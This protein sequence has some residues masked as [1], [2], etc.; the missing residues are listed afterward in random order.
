LP[1]A[2]GG[3]DIAVTTTLDHAA[4]AGAAEASPDVVGDAVGRAAAAFP[5]WRAT[6]P[7]ERAACLRR[8]AAAVRAAAD[9]L[10]DS[11]CATT[12]RLLREA[13]GSALVAADILDEAAVTGLAGGR[14][15][16]GAPGAVDWV[17]PEPRGVVAVITPWNDPL[18]AAAGLLAAALVTGNT[19][20]HKPSERSLAPGLALGHAVAGCL[21]DGVLE[22]VAG[23]AEVGRW[24]VDDARVAVVAHVG[25]SA[26]G[27]AIREACGRRGAK[28]ITE[29]G[30]KDPLVVDAGVDPRWAA[31]QIAVGAFTNAGQLCTSVER[32][33]LHRDVAAEVLAE[34]VRAAEALRGGDPR[35]ETTTLGP[36]VD[37]A[38]LAV[39]EEHVA[40]AVRR[41]ARVITGGRRLDLPGAWYAPTV[42]DR[43]T[44]DMLVMTEET[45]GPVA[46]VTVVDS[47]GEGLELAGLGRYGLA[48]TVLTPDQGHA[49]AAVDA[50]DVGTVKVN[51]VFGGAPGGSADPRRDSG[52]GRGYGPDLLGELVA[53]KAVHL[54]PAPPPGGVVAG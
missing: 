18:P 36:L 19:V 7:G 48:A 47:F 11:L 49:L 51:A 12:G 45:F 23:G 21:P 30:G 35:D 9:D 13:H 43:C 54:E 52:S 1:P 8:A 25:S 33:Y 40:D 15:L 14:A 22:V 17:R 39:V 31:R 2:R 26:A 20:V 53:L 41:G 50:L 32:V 16:M 46:P 5:G 29:N 6:A 3:K 38:Q 28:A 42:L 24:I 44:A 4:P 27:A 37:E 10:A 34:L